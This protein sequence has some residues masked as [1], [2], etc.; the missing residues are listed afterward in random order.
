MTHVK[1]SFDR[2]GQDQRY[3]PDE[4]AL[5]DAEC[6][7]FLQWALPR[8]DLRWPG[9]RR[10]R[11]QVCKRISRRMRELELG[12]IDDY[13]SFLECEPEEW[14]VLDAACRIT[15]SR[16]YRDKHVF[17]VLGDAILPELA[18]RARKEV[19]SVR[20]WCAG[21]AS[22]EELYTLAILWDWVI[23]P[24]CPGIE[25]D[26]IGSD[27]DTVMTERAKRACFASGSFKDMPPEW[28]GASFDRSNGA[29]CVKAH[30]RR[31][32]TILGQDIREDMPD[33]PFD[34]IFCRNLVFTYFERSLQLEALQRIK[35]RLRPG[36][37]LVIGAHEML[38][39]EAAGFKEV[40]G[41]REIY[42]LETQ[43]R[44]A[45]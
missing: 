13:Q 2:D 25:F 23:V 7:K 12:T 36:G 28:L 41:C 37:F 9:F 44:H 8:M 38:P 45:N 35:T 19:R 11:R 1:L 6:I 32:V 40:S 26:A 42:C 31:N 39:E 3:K 10:V 18:A 29:F 16:F 5:K 33:G 20:C 15:I 22:G 24:A 17:D 34:L 14:R 4:N 21:C 27:A 43:R 30:H